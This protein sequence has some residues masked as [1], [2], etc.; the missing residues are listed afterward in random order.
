MDI[1]DF[2]LQRELAEV[3]LLIDNLSTSQNKTM[4][5]IDKAYPIFAN[6]P[7]KS[8]LE[9]VFEIPWPRVVQSRSDQG[10]QALQAA[11]LIHAK[12]MLN[13]QAAPATGTT[14]A[15]TLMMSGEAREPT[16]R[17]GWL[18][19]SA[20]WIFGRDGWRRRRNSNDESE[21]SHV[22]PTRASLAELAYPSLSRRAWRYRLGLVLMVLFMVFWMFCT[23]FLSWDVAVGNALLKRVKDLDTPPAAYISS[24]PV[25]QATQDNPQLPVRRVRHRQALPMLPH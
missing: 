20:R 14:I 1:Q 11:K 2:V 24:L 17:S 8:W 12:D 25:D 19:R 3:Y 4:P 15:F 7:G 5:D 21:N 9:Q 23:C 16:D 18:D 13:G 10:Q 6:E 22:P